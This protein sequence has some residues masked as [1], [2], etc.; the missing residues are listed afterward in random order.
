MAS[1]TEKK[2]MYAVG[3]IVVVFLLLGQ[4]GYLASYGIGP[5]FS[6][7]GGG[8]LGTQTIDETMRNNYLK[9]VGVFLEDC[10]GFDSAAPGTLHAVNTNEN[11]YWYHFIGG[12]WIPEGGAYVPA[13]TQYFDGKAEDNGYAWIVVDSIAGQNFYVDYAKIKASNSYIVG[14]QFVDADAD[15]QKEF[16]FQ[17]DLKNHAIPS[18]GYPVIS[19]NVWM[20]VYGTPSLTVATNI[21]GIGHV[22]CTKYADSFLTINTETYGNAFYKI[23]FKM[24]TTDMT[25]AT[26]KK[27]Q[28][29]NLGNLD[30]SQFTFDI[31]DTYLR[32]TYVMSSTFDG[33]DYILRTT[34][35]PN[36]FYITQQ[37]ELTPGATDTLAVTATIYYLVAVS[38]AG[39]TVSGGWGASGS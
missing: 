16:V 7:G 24:N 23:E 14:Y 3:G 21:T 22:T 25:K 35:S 2:I 13:N 19:F 20:I 36:K 30:G 5:F 39:A 10:K 18:S 31:T 6:T 4:M 11:V 37:W 8:G 38:G 27:C 28:V 17:Y 26:L 34:G 12:Q 29:P 32:W 1:K 15:G 33:A 9:G